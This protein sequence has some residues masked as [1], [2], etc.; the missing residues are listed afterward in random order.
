MFKI[1][2]SDVYIL[3]F[4]ELLMI[5]D[6]VDRPISGLW[7]SCKFWFI[8]FLIVVGNSRQENSKWSKRIY[9]LKCALLVFLSNS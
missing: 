3:N 4:V 9:H 2:G 5:I 7:L 6:L 8:E 1:F